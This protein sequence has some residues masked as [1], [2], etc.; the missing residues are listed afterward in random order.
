MTLV[1]SNGKALQGEA[2]ELAENALYEAKLAKY[3]VWADE[4]GLMLKKVPGLFNKPEP[5]VDAKGNR[6]QI[7]GNHVKIRAS[8]CSKCEAQAPESWWR[9]GECGR[10]VFH[11]RDICPHCGHHVN[12]GMRADI[13]TGSWRQREGIFA[14]RF[15]LADVNPLLPYGLNIQENQRGLF[16]EGGELTMVMTPGH[17][18]SEDFRSEEVKQYGEHAIVFV[19]LS[20]FSLPLR[21]SGIRTK[22]SMACDVH[23]ALTLQFDQDNGNSFLCNLMRNRLTFEVGDNCSSAI[24]YDEIM[25]NLLEPTDD[26]VR[27]F[28]GN[29][30]IEELFKSASIRVDLEMA[31]MKAL[32]GHLHSH[33]LRLVRLGELDFESDVFDE[34]R[35]QEGEIEEQRRRNEFMLAADKVANDATM[36]HAVSEQEMVD[37]M[38]N[39]AQRAKISEEQRDWELKRIRRKWQYDDQLDELAQSYNLSLEKL[40][41]ASNLKKEQILRLSE[42]EMT[43]LTSSYNLKDEEQRRQAKL[44]LQAIND[45]IKEFDTRHVAELNRMLADKQNEYDKVLIE[46]RIAEVNHRIQWAK[47][48]LDS[49]IKEADAMREIRVT[50]AWAKLRE[51]IRRNRALNEIDETNKWVIVKGNKYK[52][53]DD[54]ADREVEREIRLKDAEVKRRVQAAQGYNGM[55]PLA[56][57]AAQDDPA[58]IDKLVSEH[59]GEIELRMKPDVLLAAQAKR[60]SE[61]AEEKIARMDREQ[62]ER[63]DKTL[64]ENRD[65]YEAMLKMSERMFNQM[66]EKM[67][68]PNGGS[69]S[70][71]HVIK[72]D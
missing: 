65:M 36:R 23:I 13:S 57:I 46:E 68:R 30:T 37:Y 44:R 34:L 24:G 56:V 21:V 17:Y 63:M 15:D 10:P 67:T 11:D 61:E 2:K 7:C 26:L 41:K 55:D 25:Q 18:A 70:T 19:S 53:E 1:G 64:A 8:Y 45:E 40:A 47:F 54:H 52:V 5:I 35:K 33:G 49:R 42:E 3:K 59:L 6:L 12:P 28:C 39:L 20:E 31:I 58:I 14:E 71:T 4:D 16:L 43:Q 22:E 72:Q 32:A 38:A 9:C 27:R 62:K 29:R 48:E 51:E 60:G 69:V 50:E 66:T